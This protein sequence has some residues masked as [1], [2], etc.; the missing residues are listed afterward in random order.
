MNSTAVPSYEEI[1]SQE[2]KNR[3]TGLKAVELISHIPFMLVT[4]IG[5]S[6]VLRIVYK[7]RNENR[8]T[9]YLIGSLAV[10]DLC[11]PL[12]TG[13]ELLAVLSVSRWPFGHA[14]CQFD[15]Y[16]IMALA[17]ASL[18]TMALT[19]FN[20]YLKVVRPN[21]YQTFFS[22]SRTRIIILSSWLLAFMEPVPY[23][24]SG[25]TY[26]FHSGKAFCFQ[27]NVVSYTTLLVQLYCCVPMAIVIVCYC[28]TFKKIRNHQAKI[29]NMKKGNTS[30]AAGP[31]IEEIRATRTVF[32]TVVGFMLCWTPIIVIDIIDLVRGFPSASRQV[33]VMYTFFGITS[34]AINPFIY[35]ALDRSFRKEYNKYLGFFCLRRIGITD[36]SSQIS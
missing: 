2:L 15:G 20:R 21:S 28:L 18:W 10:S 35:G 27:D 7:K 12:L 14:M 33:Y 6:L 24:A 25:K 22:K 17:F 34:S 4:I 26:K 3:S 11:L 1:F 13:W 30:V 29:K 31:S 8:M 9:Y 32:L 5:N 19:A 23:I 36:E 16:I